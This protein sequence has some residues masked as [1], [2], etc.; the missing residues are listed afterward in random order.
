M[1]FEE[2]LA[3][4]KSKVK[5]FSTTTEL[6]RKRPASAGSPDSA[7]DTQAPV[8]RPR[9]TVTAGPRLYDI[10]DK[11]YV[12]P[13]V[14]STNTDAKAAAIKQ[15]KVLVTIIDHKWCEITKKWQYQVNTD[16]SLLPPGTE[17]WLPEKSIDAGFKKGELVSV[18]VNGGWC[19]GEVFGMVE[20]AGEFCPCSALLSRDI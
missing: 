6:V 17:M 7:T 4:T 13:F 9:K 2:L 1:S 15:M 18:K 16:G 20:E 3:L 11:A 10:D 8:K 12:R 5:Q 19:E 14:S